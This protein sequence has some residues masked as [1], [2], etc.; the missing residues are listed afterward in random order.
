MIQCFSLEEVAQ[1]IAYWLHDNLI[2]KT[3]LNIN[4]EINSRYKYFYDNNYR[5]TEERKFRGEN[6]QESRQVYKYDANGNILEITKYD[7]NDKKEKLI[8]YVYT[9]YRYSWYKYKI[10]LL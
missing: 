6:E 1:L 7:I 5:L 3:W 8:K 9:Y 4:G 2:E 10:S